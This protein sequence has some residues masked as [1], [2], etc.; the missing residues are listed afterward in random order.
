MKKVYSLLIL[1]LITALAVP[2]F[3]NHIDVGK[4]V[5]TGI[6]NTEDYAYVQFDLSWE[7]MWRDVV[8]WDAAWVF[9]KYQVAGG[10]WHHA[11]LNTT[12]GNHTIPGHFTCSVGLT[13]SFSNLRTVYPSGAVVLNSDSSRST[14]KSNSLMRTVLAS[15][16]WRSSI[17]IGR[18]V[19]G[20]A[21]TVNCS[22]KKTISAH[23]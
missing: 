22:M 19:S 2:G 9:V 14:A 10:D 12:A 6:N 8:N 21:Q 18:P 7:N 3:A 23:K 13:P 15:I 16:G 17:R 1:I 4:P 5:I 11:W 20:S